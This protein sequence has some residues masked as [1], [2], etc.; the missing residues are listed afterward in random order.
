MSEYTPFGI[1]I[2]QSTLDHIREEVTAF[3]WHAMPE[4][5]GWHYG[6]DLD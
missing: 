4:D 1:D 3:R 6:A 2:P 5:R